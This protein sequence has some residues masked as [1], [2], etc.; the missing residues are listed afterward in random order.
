[1]LIILIRAGMVLTNIRI[2]KDFIISSDSGLVAT[3]VVKFKPKTIR[4]QNHKADKGK[5][6]TGYRR[7]RV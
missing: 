3:E 4:K 7:N 1:M 6:F 2:W 5:D